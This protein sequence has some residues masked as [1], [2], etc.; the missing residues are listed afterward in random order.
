MT[1]YYSEKVAYQYVTKSN[2]VRTTSL[3]K[4][5]FKETLYDVVRGIK[6][7]ADKDIL[8]TVDVLIESRQVLN[9]NNNNNNN[10]DG[11]MKVEK[12]CN[13][14]HSIETWNFQFYKFK[15]N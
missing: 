10:A 1:D 13:D 5:D 8:D 2:T 7:L 6:D 15:F 9:N 11:D 12:S 4:N 3:Q 14:E